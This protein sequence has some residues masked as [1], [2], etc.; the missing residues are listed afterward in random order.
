MIVNCTLLLLCRD[1][2]SVHPRPWNCCLPALKPGGQETGMQHLYRNLLNV[3]G[4]ACH[5]GLGVVRFG[6]SCR[7]DVLQGNAG[8]PCL[9]TVSM[10]R[11]DILFT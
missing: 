8:S 1:S 9:Y 11:C 6:A 7:M 3:E 2:A 10:Q 5:K 4:V